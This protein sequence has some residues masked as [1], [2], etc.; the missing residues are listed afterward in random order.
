[1]DPNQEQKMIKE[2][3]EGSS[4][5]N[6]PYQL[7]GIVI[8]QTGSRESSSSSIPLEEWF[9]TILIGGTES[10]AANNQLERPKIPQVPKMLRKIESNKDCFSPRMVSIGP[11]YH[12]DANLKENEKLKIKLARQYVKASLGKSID[13][14]YSK[15][16]EVAI[17]ARSYYPI[18]TVRKFNMEMFTR[19]MLLDGCFLLQFISLMVPDK[20]NYV[21]MTNIEIADVQYDLF[22]L[23]NQL[24]YN[25]LKALMDMR[26]NGDEGSKTIEMFINM[27]RGLPPAVQPWWVHKMYNR[28]FRGNAAAHHQNDPLHLLDLTRTRFVN[29]NTMV[30]GKPYHRRSN[31]WYSYYSASVLKSKGILFRPNKSGS[32]G[33][34]KFASIIR[35]ML[36]LPP[37]RIDGSTRSVLLNLVAFESS[38]YNL[39]DDRGV[40]SYLCF[41]DS[42]IDHAE[43]VMILRSANVIV[44]C[45]GNDQLVADLFNDIAKNLVPNPPTYAEAKHGIQ[46][47]CNN[48]IKKWMAE[49]VHTHCRSPWTVLALSGAIFA[50]ILTVA[51]TYLAAK[52]PR[53]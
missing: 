17:E 45:L 27:T 18:E 39:A 38:H 13:A 51:Q 28:N 5:G 24:P 7:A 46:R 42:L 4:Q 50:I 22:L 43:D 26:F 1:M 3:T 33:D 9:K 21:Q 53:N 44:N 2:N 32:F 20:Y 6:N 23:E 52:P 31:D 8:E 30:Q 48:K 41:M 14:L 40:T 11:Y 47:H 37:I 34:I 10:S 29:P 36:T 15:V 49:C 16:E 25:V 35:G 19:M 12:E